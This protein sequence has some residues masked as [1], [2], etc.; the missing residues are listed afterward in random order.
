MHPVL[1]RILDVLCLFFNDVLTRL[2]QVVAR[3]TAESLLNVWDSFLMGSKGSPL[4]N[5]KC[6]KIEFFFY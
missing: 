2:A 6:L 4:A 1:D 5:K 3:V